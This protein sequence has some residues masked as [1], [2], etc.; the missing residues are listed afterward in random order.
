MKHNTNE[1]TERLLNR[2]K[3]KQTIDKQTIGKQSSVNHNIATPSIY[4][5]KMVSASSIRN[6]ML[7][8]TLVDYL[9]EMKLV[10]PET[11]KF[12]KH[13][14]DA[15]TDFEKELLSL[16]KSK[17]FQFTQIANHHYDSRSVD[18]N[19]E[20]IEA[21]KRG[22]N[23]IYQG[24]LINTSNNTFGMPDIIIRADYI[25][26]LF[27]CNIISDEE[28]SLGSPTLGTPWH[29]KIIDVKHSTIHLDCTGVYIINNENIPAYKGQVYIYTEALNRIQG[30][31]IMKGFIWG[32]KYE[33]TSE[34][35][36]IV[37]TNLLTKLGTIDYNGRDSDY[38]T[39]TNQAIEW[40]R[41]VR[42]NSHKWTLDTDNLSTMKSELFPNMNY[43]SDSCSQKFKKEL[44]YKIGDITLLWNCGIKERMIAHSR[45]I[46]SIYD[47]RLSAEMMG[48][49]EDSRMAEIVNKM[50]DINRTKTNFSPN[51]FSAE[52]NNWLETNSNIMEF[53]ID[54]ET[55]AHSYDSTIK[56]KIIY[57]HNPSY[58]FMIGV[59]YVID[60]TQYYESFVMK[61]KT[62][63]SEKE[64]YDEFYDYIKGKMFLYKKNIA[65]F[66]HWYP[67]ETKCYNEF[68]NKH[69]SH[70]FNDENF[71]FYDLSR[72][73]TKQ[74]IIINGVYNYKLKTVARALHKMGYI[75][76]S[77]DDM[78]QCGDGLTAMFLASQYYDM[79]VEKRDDKIMNDIIEYNKVD[80]S[81]VSELLEFLRNHSNTIIL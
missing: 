22:D 3:I 14:M 19:L 21:M 75:K 56:D 73:F 68:K 1:R 54:F 69:K 41:D 58:I 13:I 28:S 67:A 52:E 5:K 10:T 37:N 80:C 63:A 46:Y 76:E 32:R 7:G 77:W 11:D 79:P 70:D 43:I 45:G 36:K 17:G 2:N 29:Y 26:K 47:S 64:M 12:I 6:Y 78:N 31:N 16:L 20:T 62:D 71:I 48:M 81:S 57:E 50:L 53:S 9:K 60:G 72:V 35:V 27:G 55:C 44:A 24:V 40:M 66:Y 42:L 4:W 74:P 39:K 34:G 8:D 61:E 59:H 38:I 30:I 65:K 33:Y 49:K 25:N 15:G 51:T 23:I 18:K